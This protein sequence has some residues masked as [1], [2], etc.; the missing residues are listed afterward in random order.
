L[1]RPIANSM[2]IDPDLVKAVIEVESSRNYKIVSHKG[3]QGLMQLIPD[4][5]ARFGVN[6]VF[7]PRENIKGGVRYLRFLLGYFE[8]NVDLVL[9]A[10][11][12]GEYAVDKHGGVPPYKETRNY[13]RKIRRYYKAESHGFDSTVGYRSRLIKGS[14]KP[15]IKPAKQLA[16]SD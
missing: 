14:K 16:K 10:Y 7:D 13:I 12:A 8:G 15:S 2:D 9:A 3:A 5:A 4:T 1:V 6:N 11:N